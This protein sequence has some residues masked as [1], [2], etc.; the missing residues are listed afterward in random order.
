MPFQGLNVTLSTSPTAVAGELSTDLSAVRHG[1]L[2]V[3]LLNRGAATVYLGGSAVTTS[4][5]PLTTSENA[6]TVQVLLG[7]T[8]YGTSTGSISL[9]VLRMGETT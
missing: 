9:G 7:E 1:N 8:L 4:G 6:I 3:L 5:F 2:R